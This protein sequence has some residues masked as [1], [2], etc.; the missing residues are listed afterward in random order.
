MHGFTTDEVSAAEARSA[1]LAAEAEAGWGEWWAEAGVEVDTADRASIR[2]AS[3]VSC[4]AHL[5]SSA[6]ST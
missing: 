3:A 6:R 4:R 5:L 1:R 2:S